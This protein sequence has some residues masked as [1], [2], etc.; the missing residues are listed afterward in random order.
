MKGRINR[1]WP[2]ADDKLVVTE[3]LNDPSSPHWKECR[4]F[5]E[6]FIQVSSVPEANKDD[7]V[8]DAMLSV[9]RYLPSFRYECRLYIWLTR[10]A[11]SRITDAYRGQKL[12]NQHISL[13]NNFSNDEEYENEILKISAPL[14]TEDE[15]LIHEAI[16]ETYA[17]MTEYLNAHANPE[18][19]RQILQRM[20]LEQYSSQEA[21]EELGVPIPV[22]RYVVRSVQRYL[23]ERTREAPPPPEPTT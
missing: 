16:R 2:G 11:N 23:R 10:I 4:R 15:C 9:I 1:D 22:M 7:V 5:F 19:N 13:Q 12:L 6:H 3:M 17:G 21:A 8:Q 14:T 20:L 18:R